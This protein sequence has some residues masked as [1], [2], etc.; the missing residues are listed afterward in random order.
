MYLLIF[1]F[2]GS[3]TLISLIN[4]F[5]RVQTKAEVRATS[6]QEQQMIA[7]AREKAWRENKQT[8][9]H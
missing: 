4:L 9:L 8:F 3:V 7:A 1:G 2:I 6:Q 5:K